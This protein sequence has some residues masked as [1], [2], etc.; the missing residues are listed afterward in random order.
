MGHSRNDSGPARGI[1]NPVG[2]VE[3]NVLEQRLDPGW[4]GEPT[5]AVSWVCGK[6][7]RENR[8]CSPPE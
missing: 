8:C 5:S 4:K 2:W 3:L 6:L 7:T 1:E